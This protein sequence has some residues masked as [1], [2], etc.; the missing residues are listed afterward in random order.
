M[1]FAGNLTFNGGPLN[2]RVNVAYAGL[3]SYS[4]SGTGTFTV[5][6]GGGNDTFWGGSAVDTLLLTGDRSDYTIS[7]ID[8]DPFL[9]DVKDNRAGSPDGTTRLLGF[10]VL[11]FADGAFPVETNAGYVVLDDIASILRVHTTASS[12]L[13]GTTAVGTVLYNE[14][15]A[16]QSGMKTAAQVMQDVATAADATTSVATMSY[17]FF[18]GTTPTLAGLDYLVSPAGGNVN[19]LNSDYYSKFSTINRYINFAS[20]LGKVGAGAA[21]FQAAYGGLSL[22]DATSKAYAAIFGVTPTADKVNHLLNDL[23]P[24]G[25]SFGTNYAREQY[26]AYYGGDGINGIGTKAAMVGWLISQADSAH[27]GTL[28][29]ANMSYL[30]DLG[31][32]KI[33]GSVDL[34]GVYHGVPYSGS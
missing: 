3:S 12:A 20:N 8:N 1:L 6:S 13:P 17:Q 14:T 11:S 10:D 19:N 21:A 30:L 4:N 27:I 24:N 22:T 2:D 18:T 23:V 31:A 33:S 32:G 7:E 34:V 26:F 5:R 9:Y 29:T 25:T 16:L 15:Q 28:E